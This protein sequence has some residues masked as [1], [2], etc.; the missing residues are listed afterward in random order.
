M[1]QCLQSQGTQRAQ[2]QEREKPLKHFLQERIE[3][4]SSK[5]SQRPKPTEHYHNLRS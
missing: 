5:L 1:Q 4:L 3:K 2:T